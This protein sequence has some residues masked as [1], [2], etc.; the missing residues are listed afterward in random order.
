MRPCPVHHLPHS[1]SLMKGQSTAYL[2]QMNALSKDLKHEDSPPSPNPNS[3]RYGITLIVFH[4]FFA[5]S[6]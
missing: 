3:H 5:N 4:P 1:P 2:L 6:I